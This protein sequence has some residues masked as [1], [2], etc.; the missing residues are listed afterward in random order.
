MAN[1]REL[2]KRINSVSTTK[3]IT[4]TMEMVSSAKISRALARANQ[5]EPYREAITD[6]M[7][8]VAGDVRANGTS[9]PL[10]QDP[11]DRKSVV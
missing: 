3:Q 11:A 4:R 10:L 8:T 5:S 6:V 7:L 9:T 2:K 1:L